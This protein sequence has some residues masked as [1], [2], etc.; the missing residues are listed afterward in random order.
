MSERIDLQ[1]SSAIKDWIQKNGFDVVNLESDSPRFFQTRFTPSAGPQVLFKVEHTF[2]LA[3]GQ[4][5]VT[6]KRNIRAADA[7]DALFQYLQGSKEHGTGN[8]EHYVGFV[9]HLKP[10]ASD[11]ENISVT[12]LSSQ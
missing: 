9:M 4:P 3:K 1:S 12:R 6:V 7:E 11:L 8:E 10:G 2:L 5:L